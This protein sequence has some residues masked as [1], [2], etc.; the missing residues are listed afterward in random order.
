MKRRIPTFLHIH[1]HPESKHQHRASLHQSHQQQQCSPLPTFSLNKATSS[2]Q[3]QPLIM[4]T[5]VFIGGDRSSVEAQSK[6][7]TA[8]IG[9]SSILRGGG[10]E[11][12]LLSS[13]AFLLP[14]FSLLF[15]SPKRPWPGR[16]RSWREFEA[17]ISRAG[18]SARVP[19]PIRYPSEEGRQIEGEEGGPGTQSVPLSRSLWEKRGAGE[20]VGLPV[21]DCPDRW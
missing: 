19:R 7:E 8:T 6:R 12:R 17:I 9:I 5:E 20:A 1:F 21:N 18:I 14:L 2:S 15:K 16:I 11:K 4:V 10:I 3:K 13:R